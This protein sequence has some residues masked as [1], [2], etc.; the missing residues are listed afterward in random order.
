METEISKE[1]AREIA[2]IMLTAD[3][4]CSFCASDLLQRFVEKF[5]YLQDAVDEVWVEDG[6]TSLSWRT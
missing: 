2:K 1:Q 4:G 3:G 6:G 5:P